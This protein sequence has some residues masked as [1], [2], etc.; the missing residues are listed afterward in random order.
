VTQVQAINA[1]LKKGEPLANRI[2]RVDHGGEHGA[3]NIYKAQAFICAWRASDLV[4]QLKIFRAH[5]ERH[6]DLFAD[7]LRQR[8]VRQGIGFRLCGLGGYVLGLITG[9]IGRSAVAATTYAVERV[10][11]RHLSEQLDY[12]RDEDRGAYAIV[13]SIVAEEQMHHDLA[14]VGARRGRFW[15]LIMIPVVSA[16]TEIVIW[17][18]MHR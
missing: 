5:E 1:R 14:S 17:V 11:L 2:L 7:E 9:L 15:P 13:Q 8:G 6:R 4:D 16:A 3:V 18:G 10:V 12:L